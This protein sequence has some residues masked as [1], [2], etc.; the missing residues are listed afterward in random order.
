L[1]FQ[2]AILEIYENIKIL[3]IK[4]IGYVFLYKIS[5]SWALFNYFL[6]FFN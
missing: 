2:P 4:T 5:L 3:L 6:I 1:G